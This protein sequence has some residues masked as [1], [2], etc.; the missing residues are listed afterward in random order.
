MPDGVFLSQNLFRVF[1]CAIFAMSAALTAI[2]SAAV[3]LTRYLFIDLGNDHSE[4]RQ[5]NDNN[6]DDIESSH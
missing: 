4:E 1:R 2:T 6:Y 3:L 5:C